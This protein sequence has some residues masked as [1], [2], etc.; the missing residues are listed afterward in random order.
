M[1]DGVEPVGSGCVAQVY[2]G[3]ARVD[4][5]EDPGFQTLVEEMER[6]EHLLEAW[7]MMPGLWGMVN[8]VWGLWKRKKGE[9]WADAPGS[10]QGG[11]L[12]EVEHLIPVAIK[13]NVTI[14]VGW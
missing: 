1:F 2:R 12:P 4:G 10:R 6:G 7:E 13:V 14:R 8:S 11:S 3:W 9:E 5:V